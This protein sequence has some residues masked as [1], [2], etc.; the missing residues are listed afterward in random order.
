M[1]Q[2]IMITGDD[3]KGFWGKIWDY[4]ANKYSCLPKMT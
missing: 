2:Q 1:E 3:E 4:L